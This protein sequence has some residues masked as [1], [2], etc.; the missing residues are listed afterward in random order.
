M[1]FFDK[2]TILFLIQFIGGGKIRGGLSGLLAM[3]G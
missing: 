1:L 2:D 3:S